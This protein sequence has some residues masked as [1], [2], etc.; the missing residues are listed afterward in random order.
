MKILHLLIRIG[1]VFTFL[2]IGCSGSNMAIAPSVQQ[3]PQVTGNN[4]NSEET[5]GSGSVHVP[6]GTYILELQENGEFSLAQTRTAGLHVNVTGILFPPNCL[7]CFKAELLD[8]IGEIWQFKFTIKNP[9]SLTGYDCRVILQEMGNISLLDISSY[10]KTFALPGDP[11]PINPFVVFD[12]GDGQNKWVPGAQ[13]SVIVTFVRPAGAKFSEIKFVVDG[14]Y[15]TNQ[16]DPYKLNEI[17]AEPPSI[18]TNGSDSTNI[19]VNAYDWQNNINF[20]NV[21][22]SAIGGSG[23]AS[24][25]KIFGNTWMLENISYT[26]G[27]GGLGPGTY[28][29]LISANSAGQETYNYVKLYVTGETE[30]F[31]T[32]IEQSAVSVLQGEDVVF[33]AIPE[34]GVPPYF[35][36]WDMDYD[37]ITFNP[38]VSGEEVQYNWTA[39]GTHDIRLRALDT[40]G[41]TAWADAEIIIVETMEVK[42]IV[43]S[44][45]GGEILSSGQDW[46]IKWN[47]YNVPGTVNI[48]YSE[49]LF[50]SDINI[51]A[52][53]VT[54]N[55]SYLWEDIPDDPT[56]TGRVA[57]VSSM[58]PAVLDISD[59]DFTIGAT[60]ITVTS[61][62][63]SELWLAESSQE[64][65][66]TSEYLPGTVKIEYSKVDFNWDFQTIAADVQNNGSFM[67]NN[68][69]CE[70][71]DTVKV[72]V[73][74][75]TYPD[76]FD[77]SDNY[78]S[79]SGPWIEI[80]K[81]NG[82]E[83]W[84]AGS[85]EEITWD[86]ISVPGNV[87]IEYSKDYF[88]T[89]VHVI[90]ASVPNTGIYTW[91]DIPYDYSKTVL[92]KV[93]S[94]A[95]SSINDVSDDYFE[96]T[97]PWIE[98]LSPN[99]Y[100]TYIRGDSEQITWTSS[101][102]TGTVN[103]TYSKDNFVSD[104]HMIAS[105]VANTGSY[106]W[107]P[108]PNDPS[109]TIKVKIT[110]TDNPVIF[111]S[112]DSFFSIVSGT[113]ELLQPN[114][115]EIWQVG[116]SHEILWDSQ[117]LLDS[118]I[119][120]FYSKSNFAT[121]SIVALS[122]LNTGLFLWD[123]IPDNVSDSVKVGIS[124]TDFP[125]VVD[126]SDQEFSIVE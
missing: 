93:T 104:L 67:W 77:D 92:V 122:Q 64:I 70:Y 102:V 16:E 3:N 27:A 114:G 107:D 29:L 18:D 55:G 90:A 71:S 6:M 45:N 69:P 109:T 5:G 89:D 111:D 36:D 9:S 43:E 57:I 33:T 50:V 11:D 15:P 22:L 126:A 108:I 39:L 119:D 4:L 30:P 35:Y 14:S 52:T 124:V 32:H 19:F 105:G 21:D 51:I 72:R 97:G 26:P 12:T 41:H 1:V 54:N 65:K 121:Y 110:S 101:G 8:V 23:S 87:I 123:S 13:A 118:P 17:K 117:N 74:S 113:I 82:G 31:G 125:D 98:L 59:T 94:I 91:H 56:A 76:I 63:G 83:I 24:M 46:E 34:N 28:D 49:D 88:V 40:G 61:P 95:D 96:I 99:G 81:P 47:S 68:I 62:N 112:S 66:W 79:I 120:I 86:S 103:I 37:G 38:D 53:N 80:T 78:F 116:S 2:A 20:V 48:A 7:D 44:P 25:S 115:G 85:D 42:I 58:Y 75:T 60:S 10:T 106:N 73:S 84:L 100:E